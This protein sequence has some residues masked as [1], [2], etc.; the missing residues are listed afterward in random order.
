MNQSTTFSLVNRNRAQF[1]MTLPWGTKGRIMESMRALAWKQDL[2]LSFAIDNDDD[3]MKTRY[4]VTVEGDHD[5]AQ[6]FKIE[7]IRMN[8]TNVN[9]PG[10][11]GQ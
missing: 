11:D 8:T 6:A 7:A 1:L 9:E 2:E 4:T 5:K 3:P 10:W